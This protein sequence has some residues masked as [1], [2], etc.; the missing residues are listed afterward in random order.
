MTTTPN[1]NSKPLYQADAA[2]DAVRL[3]VGTGAIPC[4]PWF[5][6]GIG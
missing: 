5:C 6:G 2:A 3:M 4:Q 1:K